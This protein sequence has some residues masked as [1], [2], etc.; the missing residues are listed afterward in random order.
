MPIPE[1]YDARVYAGVLGKIIGVYLGRPFEGWRHRRI[2]EELGEVYYYVHERLGKHL[3]VPDDDISGTFT[4]IRAL[5]DHG[6]SR[7]ITPEQIGQTWLN[8]LIDERTILW[9]GGMGTS[10]EHTAYLR[11]KHGV[12]APESGSMA[13][14]T[15]EVAE[16]IGAQIFIDGWAMVCPGEPELAAKL[17]RKAGSVSH[18][19]EAIYG[20]QAL[21]AMEAAAFYENDI[22]KL[23]DTGLR[24]IPGDSIIAGLIRDLR[25]WYA[26]D[27]D[28]Q[29]TFHRIEGKYGYDTYGGGCHMVPNH[30]LIV[31]ALLYGEDDFQK[32]LM[33]VNTAGWDTDCN[34]GNVGCLMGIKNGL[35]GIDAGPDWRGPV[36][37]R[38]FKVSA[39]GGD[40]MTDA[41][42]EA[43][44]L[45][46]IGRSLLEAAP[47][48]EPKGGARYHFDLP[49]AVQGFLPDDAPECS[50]AAEVENVMGFSQLGDRS[51]AVR[52]RKIAPGRPARVGVQVF[53]QPDELRRPGY[54]MVLSPSLCSGQSVKA[55]VLL[56]QGAEGPVFVSLYVAVY[57]V[58]DGAPMAILQGAETLLNPGDGNTLVWRIPDTDGLPVVRTGVMCRAEQGTSGTLY[59]DRFTWDGPP[60][61]R[62]SGASLAAHGAPVGW[63]DGVDRVRVTGTVDGTQIQLIQDE[64]RGLLINGTRDWQ[65]Y[66][67]SARVAPHMAAEA[68]VAVRAGG[69]RRFYALL[70]CAG[71]ILRLLRCR[72]EDEVLAQVD[73]PWQP[74]RGY[75]LSLKVEGN[76]LVAAVDGEEFFSVEDGTLPSGGIALVNTEGRA[77]FSDVVVAPVG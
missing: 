46:R 63:T 56:G 50:N 40:A 47:I 62:L 64:G 57:P 8:Y 13:L 65:D 39:D 9:W 11:L 14:N 10:T 66:R 6:I 25:E 51:L 61:A 23:L 5:E 58:S 24:V 35:A 53:G 73:F 32:T 74:N 68:G 72:D 7:E 31:L 76:R 12:A 29:Q 1:D 41:V 22:Q 17:A 26:L 37:D 59:L 36:A 45:S 20:A 3:V 16:Q 43:Y 71:G 4:F 15:R 27:E 67:F 21:A 18:D 42:R 60:S 30:A 77:A 33:I 28:W 54:R 34:S 44:R 70:L 38:L 69:M 55:D 75:R 52:L 49:G 19:G 2:L 48:P